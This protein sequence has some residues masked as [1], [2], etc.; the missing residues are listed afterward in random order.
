MSEDMTIPWILSGAKAKPCHQIATQVRIFDTT[1][2]LA[3]LLGL[4]QAREWE[5]KIIEEALV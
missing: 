1:P 4:S 2:T 5:G 3:H